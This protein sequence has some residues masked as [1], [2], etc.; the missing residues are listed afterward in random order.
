MLNGLFRGTVENNIDPNKLCRLQ[1]TVPEVSGGIMQ[2]A[3]PCASIGGARNF[4]AVILPPVGAN[5]WVMLERGDPELP[6]W[7]GTFWT[8][9]DPPPSASEF[10]RVFK[11]AGLTVELKDVPGQPVLQITLSSGEFVTLG[12]GAIT[13]SNGAGGNLRMEGPK[14]TVN[15]G[16]LEV[17]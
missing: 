14:V 2:W 17:I 13:L 10:F 9:D 1:V 12:S 11:C 6:V 8:P 16:A 3:M 7:M 5:V 15:N 4:G